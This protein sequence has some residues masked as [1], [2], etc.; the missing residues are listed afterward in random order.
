[1]KSGKPFA[2]AVKLAGVKTQLL[3]DISPADPKLTQEELALASASL[4]L[5][6]GDLGQLQPAPWGAFALYLDKRT[7]LN[8][9][10]WKEH[11]AT[12][13]KKLVGNNQTLI[14]QEWLNQ[15]R[16]AAQIKMLRQQRGGGA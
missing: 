9:T 6:E 4:S 10:Q 2:E 12:L 13:A 3:K 15:S 14:F 5:K 16:G 7:P 8:E 1:M 11:Q